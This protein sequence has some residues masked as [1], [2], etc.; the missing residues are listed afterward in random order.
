MKS[1]HI[2]EMLNEGKIEDLKALLSEEIY[3]SELQDKGGK[4]RYSAMKRYYRFADKDKVEMLKKPCKDIKYQGKLYNCFID[5][6]CFALTAESLDNMETYDNTNNDYFNVS[7]FISFNGDMEKLNLNKIL[8]IAKSKGY[9]FK[10]SEVDTINAVYYLKYKGSY[11]K[12][13]L[14]DKAYSIIN[15]GEEAEVYY[16]GKSDVLIIKNNIGIAGICPIIIKGDIA[17]KIIIEN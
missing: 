10:K 13:G 8:A 15:D 1:Q 7:R 11:Y 5:G 6:Y 3:K 17:N 2:L 9:K 4:A 12:I 16:S 14:L